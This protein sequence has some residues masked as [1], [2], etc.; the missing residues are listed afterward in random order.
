MIAET[1][2]PETGE[3]IKLKLPD[4]DADALN[5]LLKEYATDKQIKNSLEKL[6]I[7]AEA[8]AFMFKFAKCS[9]TVGSTVINIG[10]KILETVLT[11]TGKYPH[12]TF[13]LIFA[14]LLTFLIS[15]IPGIG[16]ILSSFLG[17][18]LMLFG[19]GRGVWE[20]LKKDNI[21]LAD[22]IIKS[23]EIFEPLKG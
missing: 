15:V 3:I 11:L 14:A 10:K 4:L 7:P 5:K 18:V 19:L 12:S 6:P 22:S 23:A 2:H 9:I 13:G 17:P 1:I 21:S 8:K 20:D 16:P